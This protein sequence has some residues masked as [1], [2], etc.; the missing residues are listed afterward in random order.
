VGNL[1]PPEKA[2]AL[3]NQLQA[4]RPDLLLLGGDYSSRDAVD[5][6]RALTG[7]ATPARP[8]ARRTPGGISSS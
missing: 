7:A 2:A 3:V 1:C 5:Y 8:G 4:L 6:V